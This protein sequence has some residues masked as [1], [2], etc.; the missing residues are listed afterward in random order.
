MT[1]QRMAREDSIQTLQASHEFRE[2]L[3]TLPLQDVWTDYTWK[4]NAFKARR[5]NND[6]LIEYKEYRTNNTVG[7]YTFNR[8]GKLA[9][10]LTRE[11]KRKAALEKMLFVPGCILLL[12][13]WIALPI[14]AV[15]I[16]YVHP[17]FSLPY[18]LIPYVLCV[19]EIVF[20][21]IMTQ[22]CGFASI[23][24]F[25][26]AS[27]VVAIICIIRL[28]INFDLTTILKF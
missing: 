2:F 14:A 12:T 3:D 18:S 8:K 24:A 7:I 16:A 23:E 19:I 9:Y 15:V 13:L 5:N 22:D 21:A 25:P 1:L 17:H 4:G 10:F 11:E 20:Y 26:F 6:L 27:G 28:Q